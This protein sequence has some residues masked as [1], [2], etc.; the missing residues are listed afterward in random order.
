MNY[1]KTTNNAN[2]EEGSDRAHRFTSATG[3]VEYFQ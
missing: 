1:S 3:T 2:N